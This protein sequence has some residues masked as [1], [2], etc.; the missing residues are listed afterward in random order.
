MGEGDVLLMKGGE[1]KGSQVLIKCTYS[2]A[3][4]NQWI[5]SIAV[6]NQLGRVEGL[7]GVN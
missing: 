7:A 1:W 3:V 2:I 4:I 6:I 5:Y